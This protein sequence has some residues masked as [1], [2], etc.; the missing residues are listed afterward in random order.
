MYQVYEGQTA[1]GRR[2]VLLQIQISFGIPGF[3]NTW[4]GEGIVTQKK[5]QTKVKE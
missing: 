1:N 3:Q 5:G 4:R 2:S